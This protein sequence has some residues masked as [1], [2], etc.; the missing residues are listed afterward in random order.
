MPEDVLVL[1]KSALRVEVAD[2]A[3]LAARSRVDHRVDQ[4]GFARIDGRFDG[5]L[6]LVGCFRLNADATKRFD[7]LVIARAFDEDGRRRIRSASRIE[8]GSAVDATIVEDD[9]A[10]RQA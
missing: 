6:Q 8:V 10:N 5:P 1:A 3:A 4:G 2:T 7:D 9:D